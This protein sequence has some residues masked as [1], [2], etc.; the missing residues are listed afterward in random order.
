MIPRRELTYFPNNYALQAVIAY[1]CAMLVVAVR[2]SSY[3]LLWYWWLFGIVGVVGFFYGS[4]KLTKKWSTYS[5]RTFKKQL[6]WTALALRVI[7]VLFLYWFF[8]ELSDKPPFMFHAADAEGYHDEAV[9][10]AEC[11]REGHFSSYLN[12]KFV[13]QNGVSDAGYPMYLGFIYLLTGD[14]ILVARLIKAIWSALTAVL[15]YKLGSRNFGEP[16]GRMAGIFVMLEPHFLIYSGL[17]LKETEM[18]FMLV[19]FLERADDLL[20]SRSFKVGSVAPVFLLAASLFCFRTVLGLAGIFAFV[21]ALLL[22]SQKVANLG[23]RWLVLIVFVLCAGYFVG[24][25]V[26]SEIETAWEGRHTNQESRYG[27]IKRSQS[28]AKYATKT[29]VAPLIFT[30]P[31]PTMVETPGQ[32]N[33]RMH[34][35]GNVVKNVMSLFCI[36]ALILLIFDKSPT[37]GWRNNVLL[38]AFMIAYLA[39]IVQSAF[40]HVDRFHLPAYM[41]ELLF[42]AYGVSQMPRIKFKQM[43]TLWCVLMFVAWVAWA[44]FKLT[45]RGLE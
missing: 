31:F 23:R 8:T 16:V 10:M 2:F 38:G 27:E 5:P 26:A 45:G 25:R 20:R 11:I 37:T 6:F 13:A 4:N 1:I 36:I 21:L 44:W 41:I 7:M 22:S 40:A 28:L 17:H 32:E 12:Y 42:A 29:V 9:W 18:I 34:H 14:S 30:I 35:A 24:G 3:S 15:I 43:Y 33:H 19:L 39:I